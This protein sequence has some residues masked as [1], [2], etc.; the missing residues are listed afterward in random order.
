MCDTSLNK[1][2]PLHTYGKDVIEVFTAQ[3][4]LKTHI[5]GL[6]TTLGN[7]SSGS[8]WC[9]KAL[10]P[11]DPLTEVRGIPDHSAVPSVL[12]NYQ[13]TFTVNCPSSGTGTWGF[14]STFLPHPINF[15][16][17]TN[18]RMNDSATVGEQ[19]LNPQ[20]EG[21]SHTE[22][23]RNFKNLAQRWRLAYAGISCYQDG[24]DLSNQGTIVVA[25]SPVAP[26]TRYASPLWGETL[27]PMKKILMYTDEDKPD[28]EKSQAMPNAYFN[29]SKEGAYVPLK[30]TDSCQKWSTESDDV[31]FGLM[32]D[33]ADHDVFG[34]LRSTPYTTQDQYPHH[35]MDAT[36]NLDPIYVSYSSGVMTG[37]HG[38]ST[39]RML[40]GT[41]AHICARN[42]DPVTSFSFFVRVGIEMQISPSSVLA[43]QMKL[44]P[45]YDPLAL[46]TY[47]RIARELKDAYPVDYN[48]LG[49]LWDVISGAAKTVLPMMR[50]MG[51]TGQLV[52]TVGDTVVR[53][54]D[55]IRSKKKKGKKVTPKS[56]V[57]VINAS[58]RDRPPAA[59]VERLRAQ[60]A[61]A[62][63]TTV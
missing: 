1:S 30:L 29:Q 15:L 23:Y 38:Q 19:Y 12:M 13:A 47:F 52:S 7:T 58:G 27:E 17:M 54:G 24:P 33:I 20:I 9:L 22:K 8:D 44:S 62:A 21:T 53:V 4:K 46:D 63:T 60:K 42:L 35:Q 61:R 41:F 11:S 25:Q 16:T 3:Q 56:I 26:V 45:P 59:T 43:P 51:P 6:A 14:N 2:T 50:N 48:D 55:K 37:A 36:N 34:V 32:T 10:H 57:K 28:Y 40:N 18:F 49:K 39:S 5:A 31:G